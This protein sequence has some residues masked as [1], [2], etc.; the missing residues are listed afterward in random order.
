MDGSLLLAQ[1]GQSQ[2][3]QDGQSQHVQHGQSQHVQHGQSGSLMHSLAQSGSLMHSLAQS[4]SVWLSLS[5]RI[6]ERVRS[7]AKDITFRNNRALEKLIKLLKMV[8]SCSDHIALKRL[9]MSL[10]VVSNWI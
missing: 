5:L 3:V 6:H 1:D 8:F 2:H 10:M 4:G 9:V 7:G